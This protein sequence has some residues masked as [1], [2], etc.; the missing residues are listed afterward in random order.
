[1][2]EVLPL[3]S[4][5]WGWALVPWVFEG[6]PSAPTLGHPPIHKEVAVAF[7]A[8]AEHP[9]ISH[10]SQQSVPEAFS[11]PLE[12]SQPLSGLVDDY[13]I[14]PKH[15]WPRGPRPL[16]SGAQQRKRDGPDLAEY[17]YDAH[18]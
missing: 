14:L 16:L 5:E 17:Y 10:R 6:L 9:N 11:A 3:P 15:P 12:L 13:G 8:R 1:M 18:L 4:L 7:W 2:V